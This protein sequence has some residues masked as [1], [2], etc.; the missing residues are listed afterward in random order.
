M[1]WVTEALELLAKIANSGAIEAVKEGI[2][3]LSAGVH[4][5][6]S[7]AIV[8]DKLKALNRVAADNA[9]AAKELH[10]KYHTDPTVD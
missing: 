6:T 9:E 2:A 8:L 3:A 7:P 10:A 1:S 4:G 5:K